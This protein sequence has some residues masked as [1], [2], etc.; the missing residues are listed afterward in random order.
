M[1]EDNFS[2]QSIIDAALVEPREPREIKSWHASGF[3]SCPTGRYL[4]RMGVPADEEFDERTLR[5]FS[6]GKKFEDW[7]LELGTKQ[8]P[9]GCVVEEQV[10]IENPNLGVTGYADAVVTLPT[11]KKLVYEIKSKNSNAFHWMRKRG[12]SAMRQHEMQIWL[13]L[14]TLEIEEGRIL[15][16]SKD[17]LCMQEAVVMRSDVKLR[18]EVEAEATLLM[19][20][21]VE[22][23]PPPPPTDPTD[24][25]CKYCRWHKQCVAQEKYLEV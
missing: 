21:L 3:G 16:I 19:R 9:E 25:R 18:S 13:Y 15:Y 22:K 1:N 14:E 17:D 23:L 10:R 7:V 11:G 12:E 5:I 8:L 24:W 2:L 4:E 20:A 6:A